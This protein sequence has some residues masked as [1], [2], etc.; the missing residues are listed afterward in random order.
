MSGRGIPVLWLCGPPGVGKSTVSWQ[1]Y[2]ELA[3]VGAHVAF[4]ESDQLGMCYPAPPGDPGRD[5][6]KALN[7][8]CVL[9]NFRAAGARCAVVNG[10]L[11][12]AGLPPAWL[13]DADVSICRLR[14]GADDVARRFTAREGPRD[15]MGETLRQIRKESQRLDRSSLAGACVDTTGVPAGAVAALVR[16]ACADWPGFTGDLPDTAGPFPA[17]RHPMAGGQVALITGPAGVGKSTI[18]FRVYLSC[19]RA[20]LTAGY[21][22]LRQIGFL[23]PASESDPGHHRLR[24]AN[25]AVIW[26]N[27]QAAGATH[28]I[29]TGPAGG[30]D[31]F[32]RYAEAL[33]G[34]DLTLARLRAGPQELTRRIMSR[35]AGGSWP[36][37]GD[38]LRGRPAVFLA[39]V[40]RRAAQ[41][42]A[43]QDQAEQDAAPGG[44]LAA[45]GFTIDTTG[46]TPDESAGLIAEALGWPDPCGVHFP[47]GG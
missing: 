18:G 40:A 19:L 15:D 7:T 25:L 33:S 36:E 17:R 14:A 34:A 39:G 43:A 5:Q 30:R 20:G 1:L 11:G 23:S 6:L 9:A 27:Y 47:G 31:G 29:A 16:A 26:R 4:A 21:V 24:V 3:D 37:P 41:D 44:R 22:D 42:Q 12:P 45:G 35:G 2:A 38:P 32:A 13:P 28:L 8:G 46:R 10:V